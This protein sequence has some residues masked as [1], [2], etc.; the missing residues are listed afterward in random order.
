MESVY[1]YVEQKPMNSPSVFN[2][3]QQFYQPIGPLEDEQ[4]YAPEFQITNS[5]TIVG[6]LNGLN[7]WMVRNDPADEKGLF[8]GESIPDNERAFYDLSIELSLA[9]DDDELHIL[10]DRLDMLLAHGLLSDESKN[11]IVEALKEFPTD[12]ERDIDE[13]ARIAIYLVLSSPE[14][15]I[16]R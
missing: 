4:L 16:N 15:L 12:D 3:F 5:Q 2:F 1:N 6:Y 7:D 14:Y 8:S 9:D 10:V 11:L 13:R